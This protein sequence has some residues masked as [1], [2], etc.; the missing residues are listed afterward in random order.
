MKLAKSLGKVVVA[1][2][3]E[4]KETAIILKDLQC[5]YIQ[6]NWFIEPKPIDRLI[7]YIHQ[8]MFEVEEQNEAVNH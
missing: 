3:V 4:S 5:D 8:H 7:P 6:G 1:E 2:G